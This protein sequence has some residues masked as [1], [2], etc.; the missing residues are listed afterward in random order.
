TTSPYTLTKGQFLL[1]ERFEHVP[2]RT[3]KKFKR[4]GFSATAQEP[5]QRTSQVEMFNFNNFM[6]GY[7]ITNAL[8]AYAIVPYA[9]KTANGMFQQANGSL[10]KERYTVSGFGDTEFMLQYGFKR[11]ARDGIEGWYAYNKDDQ[12]SIR[13]HNVKE[14]KFTVYGSISMPNGS[15][16]RGDPSGEPADSGLQAGWG[17]PS[18]NLGGAVAQPFLDHWTMLAETSYRTFSEAGTMGK[19][20][21][22]FRVNSA[23]GYQLLENSGGFLSRIDVFQEINYLHLRRD[24]NENRVPDNASGGDIV[25]FA[26]SLRLTF[27]KVSIGIIAKFPWLT[28]LNSRSEQQGGEGLEKYRIAVTVSLPL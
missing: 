16:H 13:K 23:L 19:T 10:T 4:S 22:E 21:N 28:D 18:L 14:T 7:G 25:Y 9:E 15:I 8:T 20:G 2:F 27:K 17:A 12:G 11:G 1:Y 24:I 5:E 6:L 26:P 3:F